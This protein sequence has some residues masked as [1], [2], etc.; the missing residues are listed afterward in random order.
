MPD[1]PPQDELLTRLLDMVPFAARLGV[2][3][4]EAGPDRVGGTLDWSPDVCTAGAVLHG[5]ALMS[6]ADTVGAVC[7]FL[8]LPSGATTSTVESK[9]NFFRAVRA[10]TAR[11]VA[12]PLHV[13]GSFVVVQT[14]VYDDEG[15]L[16][17]QTTQTQAVLSP[18]RA[19][20]RSAGC[21][22]CEPA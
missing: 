19:G 16:V 5:G 13:G 7:A 2:A 1:T 21:A 17:G 20:G 22:R 6:L 12:R 8:N 15:R 18:G 11:A 9:T 14:E 4:T 10:G 3:F